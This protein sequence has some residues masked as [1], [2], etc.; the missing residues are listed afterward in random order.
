[1]VKLGIAIWNANSSLIMIISY[2]DV[3]FELPFVRDKEYGI[4]AL[5]SETNETHILATL[6]CASSF[7]SPRAS[8]SIIKEHRHPLWELLA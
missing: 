8:V 4:S 7:L 6:S 3:L 2:S 5:S 1:M